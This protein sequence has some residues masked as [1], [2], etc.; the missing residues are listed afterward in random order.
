[1]S[2][3]TKIIHTVVVGD[4]LQSLAKHYYDADYQWQKIINANPWLAE[5]NRLNH[6]ATVLYPEEKLE[7]PLAGNYT[8]TVI[9]PGTLV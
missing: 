6:E 9:V 7:I 5:P 3:S 4:T 1:M 8:D 2:K